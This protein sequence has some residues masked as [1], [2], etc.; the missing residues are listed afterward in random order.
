VLLAH[1]LR[2]GDQ[3]IAVFMI[4]LVRVLTGARVRWLGAAPSLRQRIYFANHTSNLDSL[5][6]WA[7]L[8]PGIRAKTRP[9]A[10]RDYWV[11]GPLRSYLAN[12][13]FHA[14][15]IER[16][17]VTVSDNPLEQMMEVLK[18]GSSLIIF[19][20]GGRQSGPEPVAFKGGL[21]HLAKKMPEVEFVPVYLENLN[22]VLPKGEILPVPMLG[23]ITVGEPIRLETEETKPAFLERARLAVWN[24]RLT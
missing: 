7:A 8:P 20:E 13:V 3:M 6:L 14:V 2:F 16:K 23:S 1:C 12:N 19:P 22:R 10:A 18:A 11:K 15:L 17:K 5:V 24:L 21:F 9:I 4:A